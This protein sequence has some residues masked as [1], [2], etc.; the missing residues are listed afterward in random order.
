[1][2]DTLHTSMK[3]NNETHLYNHICQQNLLLCFVGI[4]L[5]LSPQNWN[6]KS[7]TTH[8][9][10]DMGSGAQ[11]PKFAW[12]AFY[13]LSYLPSHQNSPNQS[14]GMQWIVC[15]VVCLRIFTK[16]YNLPPQISGVPMELY[17]L[18]SQDRIFQKDL[19]L[20]HRLRQA[21]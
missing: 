20:P 12:R 10:F 4:L 13:K 7:V 19:E 5:A 6:Q 9:A 1:M 8:L 21:E 14:Y 17:T 2:T 16:L 15:F 11:T 3:C 18:C